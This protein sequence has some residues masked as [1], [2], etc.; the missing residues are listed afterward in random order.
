MTEVPAWIGRSLEGSLEGVSRNELRTQSLRISDAYRAGR[1]SDVVR[2]EHDAIAYAIARMPATYA[3]AHASLDSAA[4]LLPDFVPRTVLD[5]G[6]GPGTAAWACIELWPSLDH[7]T[8]IDSNPRLLDLA[9]RFSASPDAPAVDTQFVAGSIP[10]VL[11]GIS[12]ADVVVASYSLTEIQQPALE[13]VLEELWRLAATLLVIVEPGTPDGF[14]RILSCRDMLVSAGGR[15]VAPCTHDG[16]CPLSAAARW[17]HFSKRLARSR[18]HLIAKNASVPFEDERFSY[19]A[20]AKGITPARTHQRVLA[21]PKVSKG[22]VSLTLCAPGVVEERIVGRGDRDAYKA[23][24]RYD[25]G[26]AVWL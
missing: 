3:A 18:D 25:W 21:T 15:V 16:L 26:D 20:V 22:Q 6:A 17:C 14:R 9:R 12:A 4:V 5:I 23:A 8:L 1:A 7:A 10:Q 19:L 13:R 24:K 11:P 2:T